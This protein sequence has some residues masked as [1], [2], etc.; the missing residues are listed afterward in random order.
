MQLHFKSNEGEE[1]VTRPL[2]GHD[3]HGLGSSFEFLVKPLDDVCGPER[4]PFFLRTIEESKAGVEG[5][6][7][8]LYRRREPAFPFRL[9]FS[10]EFSRLLLGRCIEDGA[11]A[12]SNGLFEFLRHFGRKKG[13]AT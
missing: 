5:F 3:L 10:E 13:K 1:G 2:P 8:A 11:H 4:N 7:Q 12:V 6:F 9:E